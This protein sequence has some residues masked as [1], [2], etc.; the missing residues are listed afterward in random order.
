MDL[1]NTA[2]LHLDAVLIAL[3]RLP[4]GPASGFWF[5]A[6]LLAVLCAVFGEYAMALVY[7]ANRKHYAEQSR[8]MARMHNLSI[9]AIQAKDKAAYLAANRL[10]NDAFGKAFFSRSGLFA[11]S[12]WP[13]PLALAWLST[14]FSGLDIPVPGLGMSLGFVGAFLAAYIPVRVLMPRLGDALPLVGRARALARSETQDEEML[15]WSDL[16]TTPAGPDAPASGEPA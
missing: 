11:A 2:Y 13:V 14:R 15:A 5:G 4:S 6:L 7:V 10:A 9:R 8:S 12:L 3:F 1:I 16:M